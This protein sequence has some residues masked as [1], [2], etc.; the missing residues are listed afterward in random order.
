MKI[1][2]LENLEMVSYAVS[3]E[4]VRIKSSME[5]SGDPF[6]LVNTLERKAYM[7]VSNRDIYV[8][9]PFPTEEDDKATSTT[10]KPH[11]VKTGES[12]T[13]LGFPCN[14]WVL[15]EDDVTTEIW[16]TASLGTYVGMQLKPV[17]TT[18][19]SFAWESGLRSRG[20]FPLRLVQRNANGSEIYQLE[21]LSVK[22]E[23]VNDG[24]FQIP[25]GFEKVS[26]M[27]F[28]KKR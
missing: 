5:T 2:D 12:E 15:S 7:V 8:E 20:L 25:P 21:V 26:L 3:G 14:E 1:L 19:A 28:L 27:D 17:N 9:M 18:V 13:I 16:A 4:K 6:L 24:L 10:Q 11:L 23:R 22:R